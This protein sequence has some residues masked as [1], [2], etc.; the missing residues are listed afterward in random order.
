MLT[1][2]FVLLCRVVR[3]SLTRT[4]SHCVRVR[5]VAPRARPPCPRRPRPRGASSRASTSAAAHARAHARR[6]CAHAVAAAVAAGSAVAAD[7]D[8]AARVRGRHRTPAIAEAHL[9][10]VAAAVGTERGIAAAPAAASVAAAAA[11][12]VVAAIVIAKPRATG[13]VARR[14]QFR[15]P[16]R[17]VIDAPAHRIGDEGD[18]LCAHWRQITMTNT[19]ANNI[20]SKLLHVCA[21][22]LAL[23]RAE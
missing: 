12:V 15:A 5:P 19:Q 1:F 7:D 20:Q 2:V 6:A 3:P 10:A 18:P 17:A 14:L 9:V 4:W 13:T 22:P 11:A 21:S 16:S 23:A 8:P